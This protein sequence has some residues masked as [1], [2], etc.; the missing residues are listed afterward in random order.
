M[1]TSLKRSP[2]PSGQPCPSRLVAFRRAASAGW[3][4]LPAA[5][6][7]LGLALGAVT[8]ARAAPPIVI[9]SA[10]AGPVPIFI[11]AV[12]EVDIVTG[13]SVTNPAGVA[14]W[15]NG[16]TLSMTGGSVSAT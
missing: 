4:P 15:V 12:E 1:K 16:G 8:P 6:L 9:D 3:R 11:N 14:A 7:V 2:P 10:W 5:L 13:G